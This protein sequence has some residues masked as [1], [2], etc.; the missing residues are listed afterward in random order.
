MQYTAN[1]QWYLALTARWARRISDGETAGV[2][3]DPVP[4]VDFAEQTLALRPGMRV[5]DL[6]ASWGR[7]SLELAR[8]GYAVTAFDLSPDLLEI[9]RRRA[10]REGLSVEFCQGTARRLPD[11][12]RFDAVCAFYDDCLLSFEDE[13]D[14]FAALAAVAATLP[15]GGPLLF[16]TTDCPPLLPPCQVTVAQDGEEEIEETIRFDAATRTGTSRRVHRFVDGRVECFERRRHHYLPDEAAGLLSRAGL[17]V[18]GCWNAYDPALTYGYR[19]EGMV[20]AAVRIGADDECQTR[21]K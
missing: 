10:Q 20:I 12:G 15:P 7:T 11:L 13:E 3:H 9:G 1:E 17:R 18:T 19:P 5:L 6:A 21:H 14:N 8:R 2:H 4:D 16:G